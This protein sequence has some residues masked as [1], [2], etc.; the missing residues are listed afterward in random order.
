MNTKEALKELRGMIPEGSSLLAVEYRGEAL[1]SCDTC[2]EGIFWPDASRQEVE[3][4]I[5]E[6]LNCEG[7][8]PIS[9]EEY[10]YRHHRD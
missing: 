5:K 4:F 8:D 1:L 7:Y 2:E 9:Q 6:H 10:N 3:T